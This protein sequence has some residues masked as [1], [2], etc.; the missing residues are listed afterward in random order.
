MELRKEIQ[1]DSVGDYTQSVVAVVR[2]ILLSILS[3]ISGSRTAGD[4]H[5]TERIRLLQLLRT[6]RQSGTD[7]GISFEYTVH[8]A[9]MNRNPE[10]MDRIDSALTTLC[11]IR[12]DAPSSLFFG[13][14]KQGTIGLIR[15]REGDYT[16]DSLV[17][18]DRHGR[19]ANLRKFVDRVAIEFGKRNVTDRLSSSINGLWQGRLFVGQPCTDQWV[20]T[21]VKI[22]PL[23]RDGSEALRLAIVPSQHES[24]DRIALIEDKNLMVVPLPYDGSFMQTFYRGWQIVVQFIAADATVPGEA[25]LVKSEDRQIAR[26]LSHRRNLP[27]SEVLESLQQL[28]QPMLFETQRET[29]EAFLPD[30]KASVVDALV[31]PLAEGF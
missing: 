2:S 12:G 1:K 29:V 23:Q 16:D 15:S 14:E 4:L 8:E 30:G 18:S 3:S 25:S 21:I 28:A 26:F 10:I 7:I 17:L 22:D 24:A 20:A 19:F 6:Y 13:V 11:G 27:V 5:S 31:A 9:I